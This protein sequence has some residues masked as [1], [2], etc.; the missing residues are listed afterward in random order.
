[1][2]QASQTNLDVCARRDKYFLIFVSSPAYNYILFFCRCG[3]SCILSPGVYASA[4]LEQLTVAAE[5]AEAHLLTTFQVPPSQTPP[6]LEF[7]PSRCFFLLF[8]C[9]LS[10]LDRINLTPKISMP[11]WQNRSVSRQ[12]T[13]VENLEFRTALPPL[14]S[15]TLRFQFR[16]WTS[17]LSASPPMAGLR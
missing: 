2:N 3:Y 13:A 10:E 16:S 11:E 17:C 4:L 8:F 15:H 9:L 12:Q 7:R 1:M 14:P 5:S 6:P